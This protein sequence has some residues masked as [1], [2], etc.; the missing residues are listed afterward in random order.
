MYIGAVLLEMGGP[1]SSPKNQLLRREGISIPLQPALL[2][3]LLTTLL[4]LRGCVGHD[5]CHTHSVNKTLQAADICM[6]FQLCL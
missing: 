2:S 1:E 5:T 3:R 6:N 4:G